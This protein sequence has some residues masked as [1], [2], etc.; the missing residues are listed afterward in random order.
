MPGEKDH[1]VGINRCIHI[2]GM[3]QPSFRF[4]KCIRPPLLLP[5]PTGISGQ[6]LFDMVPDVHSRL[7]L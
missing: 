7:I 1:Q 6:Q 4:K 5:L 3:D 2:F